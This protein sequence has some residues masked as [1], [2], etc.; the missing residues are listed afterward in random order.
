MCLATIAK[1]LQP[2]K[3]F[4]ENK[5]S[6]FIFLAARLLVAK[7]F[8]FSGKLKLDYILNND[9]DTLYFLFQDYNVPLLPVKVAAW[10]GMMGELTFS[11]L[12]AFGLFGR[13]GALGL[14]FMSGMVYMTDQN[15]MAPLWAM[16]CL[17]VA[18]YGPGKFSVDHYLFRDKKKSKASALRRFLGR[19]MPG[20]GGR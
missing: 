8:F 1:R 14:V 17:I 20:I 11:I 12:L 7:D 19:L 15:S 3:V 16:L 18:T 10:M 5:L 2:L 4:A 6:P 9:A 13:V